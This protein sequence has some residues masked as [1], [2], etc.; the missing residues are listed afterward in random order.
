MQVSLPKICEKLLLK[1]SIELQ[2]IADNK[3][4]SFQNGIDLGV[5]GGFSGSGGTP[6]V[7]PIRGTLSC[8]IFALVSLANQKYLSFKI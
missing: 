8:R 1:K 4:Q 6:P 7:P 5:G 2:R 3:L